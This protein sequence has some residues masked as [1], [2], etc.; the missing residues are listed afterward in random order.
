M[1][2]RCWICKYMIMK[3]LTTRILTFCLFAFISASILSAQVPGWE[4]K[5]KSTTFKVSTFTAAGD[6]IGEAYGF[7][8]QKDEGVSIYSIF[9]GA[10]KA[11]IVDASGKEYQV[12]SMLAADDIYD[13]VR[14][15]LNANVK[16]FVTVSSTPAADNAKVYMVAYP[17][18]EIRSKGGDVVKT[19]SFREKYTY[20]TISL[21][22]KSNIA[23]SLLANENGEAIGIL[24]DCASQYDDNNYAI[25]ANFITEIPLSGLSVN[26]KA[27][28]NIDIKTALP[29]DPDQA[30]LFL[31][32]SS[33]VLSKEKYASVVSDFISKFPKSADGYAALARRYASENQYD[34][35][36][37]EFEH[38][39]SLN[40][41]Q[42]YHN[43][44]SHMYLSKALWLIEQEKYR[45]AVMAFNEVPALTADTLDASFYYAREQAEVHCRMFQQALDDLDT[46]IVKSPTNEMFHAEK[47]RVHY[48]VS[49]YDEG[50]E[51]AQKCI[52]LSPE[53]D[54]AHLILGLCYIGKGEKEEGLKYV[55]KAKELGNAQ[56]EALY[57]KYK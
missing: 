54:V 12:E 17:K 19:E 42:L 9:Q 22:T 46:A 16:N 4:K 2:K 57:E 3:R 37:R 48:L 52:S 35:A 38:A 28:Q 14:F 34:D 36:Q 10:A 26:T 47:A 56:A 15:R 1:P 24:Q 32:L 29:D 41:S 27:L 44:L 31:T 25:S 51:V 50:I 7:F 53:Y 20:Y 39:Y 13:V 23:G 11:I 43:Q 21:Q 33:S 49:Q 8:T 40:P 30:F 5:V 55:L 18:G 45:D 6:K